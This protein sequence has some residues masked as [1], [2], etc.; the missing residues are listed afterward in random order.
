MENYAT[1]KARR[2]GQ[3]APGSLAAIPAMDRSGLLSHGDTQ[4]QRCWLGRSPGVRV[5][6]NQC[7]IQYLLILF[8]T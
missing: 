3:M 2:F 7:E 1:T 5:S 6:D 8:C 4:A